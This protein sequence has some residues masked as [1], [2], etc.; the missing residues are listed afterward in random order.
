M[1]LEVI[2]EAWESFTAE[3]RSCL[4]RFSFN[5]SSKPGA[6]PY[7]RSRGEL[8]NVDIRYLGI[9]KVVRRLKDGG[10]LKQPLPW[11]FSRTQSSRT[12]TQRH[13]TI[14]QNM[15]TWAYKDLLSARK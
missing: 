4:R 7:E 6:L 3:Q 9:Q 10:G 8:H 12:G 13:L 1:I 11:Q 2:L 15:K 14:S 5:D